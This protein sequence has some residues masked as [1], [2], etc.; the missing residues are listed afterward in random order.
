VNPPTV[1]IERS[2]ATTYS[3]EWASADEFP[4]KRL[5]RE[6][7]SRLEPGS[8][9]LFRG[10]VQPGNRVVVK[11]NWVLHFHPYGLDPFS[12]IT[13][14]SVLRAVV[15]LIYEALGGDGEIVIADAPQFNCDFAKLLAV[16][17]VEQI[18]HH[19]RSRHG[20]EV[21]IRDLR[22]IACLAPDLTFIRAEDRV[23]L[24]G[25]PDGYAVVDLGEQSAF[26]DM[27]S[28]ERIYGADYDRRETVRHHNAE[29][30]EYLVAKTILDS[31]VVVHVPKL[32]VHKKVGV[33]INAKGMVGINGNKNWLAHY[34]VGSPTSGGDEFPAS[35]PFG[36]HARAHV[37]RWAIDHLL[38]PQSRSGEYAFRAA[39]GAFS[40]LRPAGMAVARRFPRLGPGDLML[41]GG[42]WYGNDTAWRMTVDLARTVLYSDGEGRLQEQPQRR[43]V[44]VVDGIVAGE[45][46]G[47][48][49][50][51]PKPCGVLLGGTGLLAVDVVAARL[52]GFDPRKLRYQHWLMRESPQGMGVREPAE[53]EVRSN[54]PEW[55]RLM[56]DPDVPD[57]DFE[58]HPGWAGH[59]EIRPA[60][61]AA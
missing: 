29:R 33:T 39:R 48:L 23:E 47:P 9:N 24:P 16:T 28:P 12:V 44:S 61:A 31:D 18:A 53:V 55:E 30:H 52:M 10:Q 22:Q 49:S 17:Q 32:K 37:M 26:R 58:P 5:L 1:G 45:R 46:E 15:D 57:L 21:A 6:L 19:Y 27:P 56:T 3:S 50:P 41:H 38:V 40:L 60:A 14:S 36:G 54:V 43:F 42:N 8:D 7:S 11:P 59:I 20:F 4:E 51:T 35:E 13:H 2:A 25:D 34:R